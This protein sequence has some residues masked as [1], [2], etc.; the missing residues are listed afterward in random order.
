MGSAA[1]QRHIL[2]IDDSPEILDVVKEI[3]MDEGYRVSTSLAPIAPAALDTLAPDLIVQDLLFDGK[4]DAAL[5]DLALTHST[6]EF[7]GIP[8]ILCTAAS[9][10]VREPAMAARLDRLGVRVLLKP[11]LLE[12][13]LAAVADAFTTNRLLDRA[14]AAQNQVPAPSP[15]LPGDRSGQYASSP[16]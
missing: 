3:L 15:A 5:S 7:A 6:P 2:L 4:P 10:L 16:G 8:R 12:D 11:F 9:D 14:H 13:L 1:S